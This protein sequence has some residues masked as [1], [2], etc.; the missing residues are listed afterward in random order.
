LSTNTQ[1]SAPEVQGLLAQLRTTK[2]RRPSIR[3]DIEGAKTE[4]DRAEAIAAALRSRLA[5]RELDL[6]RTGAPVPK[7]PFPE[8]GQL[9]EA[10]RA[11]RVLKTRVGLQRERLTVC[12]AEIGELKQKLESAW[13]RFGDEGYQQAGLRFREA[14][15]PLRKSYVEMVAY[16]HETGYGGAKRILPALIIE[17]TLPQ[18]IL[19]RFLLHGDIH[20]D[21]RN[22]EPLAPE[23]FAGLRALRSEV[24]QAKSDEAE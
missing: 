1:I 22:A 3:A 14:V 23:L 2:A 11:V 16:L 20:S 9:N 10:E 6:A 5:E 15:L 4:L 19:D 7:D 18:P 12:E 21:K 8:E 17:D 13:K 24:E